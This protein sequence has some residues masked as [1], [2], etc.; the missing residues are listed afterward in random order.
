MSVFQEYSELEAATLFF[1]QNFQRGPH[2]LP[3]VERHH[4]WIFGFLWRR[5][6]VD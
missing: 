4:P 5:M 2:P 3:I 6:H 1:L